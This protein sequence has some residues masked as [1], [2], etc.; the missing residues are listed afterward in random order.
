MVLPVPTLSLEVHPS[1]G[2]ICQA[3]TQRYQGMAIVTAGTPLV[4]GW[5]KKRFEARLKHT[6]TP[7]L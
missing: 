5:G 3:Q 2:K 4:V 7:A 1:A 6:L